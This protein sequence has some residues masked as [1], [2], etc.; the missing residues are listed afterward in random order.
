MRFKLASLAAAATLGLALWTPAHALELAGVKVEDSVKVAGK[1]LVLNGAGIRTKV[2]FKVY[3]VSLYMAE[4]KTTTPEVLAVPGPKRFKLVM[5]RD[6][7]G[8]EFGQAFLTGINKNLEKDEKT[9]FVNQLLK[10]GETFETIEGLKKGDV[11]TGDW[12][13]GTG[14][15]IAVN[16]KPVVSPLPDVLFYNAILRI[17]LGDAP[18]EASLKPQLLGAS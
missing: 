6:L 16:G 7:S 9:K 4:K 15:V 14:T 8:E 10:L 13:P 12:T 18:A 2:V 3:V 5:L 17:W 11:V 1:D